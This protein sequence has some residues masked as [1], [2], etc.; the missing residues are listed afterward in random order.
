MV[1]RD[2]VLRDM[3]RRLWARL[4]PK[5]GRYKL[6]FI[7]SRGITSRSITSRSTTSRL[8]QSLTT[9]RPLICPFSILSK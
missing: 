8:N 4:P 2:V 5:G 3:R 6:R 7:M 1:R 9:A